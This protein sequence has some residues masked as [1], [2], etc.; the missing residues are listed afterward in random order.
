MVYCLIC[1][2]SVV[3]FFFT[4]PR[5]KEFLLRYQGVQK[6][7]ILHRSGQK[8][9]YTS[10]CLFF[11]LV[12]KV[13]RHTLTIKYSCFKEGQNISFKRKTYNILQAF[14]YHVWIEERRK[15]TEKKKCCFH[16]LL[17]LISYIHI[18]NIHRPKSFWHV[19]KTQ[20][21]FK[22]WKCHCKWVIGNWIIHTGLTIQIYLHNAGQQSK[23]QLRIQ[24][25]NRV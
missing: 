20:S 8:A 6:G 19:E 12:M 18:A 23:I 2:F 4:F 21:I 24:R 9:Q 1:W 13:Y 22:N 15:K 16:S 3:H 5:G 7:E 14:L 11:F 17:L 25:V 10:F